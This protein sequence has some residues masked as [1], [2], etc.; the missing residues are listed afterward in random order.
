MRYPPLT[1]GFLIRR[2]NRF[3]ARVQLETGEI[4]NAYVPSTGR[5]TG[6]L[7]PGGRVWLARAQNPGRKTAYILLLTELAQGGLCSVNAALANQLFVEALE[8]G[9]LA[10]FPFQHIEKEVTYG[11]SRLDFRLSAGENSCWVEVKSVSYVAE[12]VGMFPDAPTARGQRQLEVLAELVAKGYRA[13]V[14]FIAQRADA[15]S[16]SPH[17][18]IDPNFAETLR[19]VHQQGVAIHAYR[20]DVSLE[21]IEITDEIMVDIENNNE[22]FS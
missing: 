4:Q 16:F 22:N 9:R 20:C 12:G 18:A 5:L 1:P 7:K 11:H 13:S 8:N 21:K 3:V 17:V 2:D 15:N 10:G 6:A 14:V 19:C